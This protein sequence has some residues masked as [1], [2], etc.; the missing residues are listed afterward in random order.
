[1][2]LRPARWRLPDYDGDAS[3]DDRP[4]RGCGRPRVTGAQS[5][6]ISTAAAKPGAVTMNSESL[7]LDL[8]EDQVITMALLADKV[9]SADAF[10]Q[11]YAA[12]VQEH[13]QARGIH[14]DED[15][16]LKEASALHDYL[17][18]L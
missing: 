2:S 8:A 16:A 6:Q 18:G 5:R 15:H 14:L 1:L 9:L 12:L 7:Y 13:Y 17:L 10:A 4:A 11:K 3:I